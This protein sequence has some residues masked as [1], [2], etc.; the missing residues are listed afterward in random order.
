MP[1]RKILQQGMDKK[2]T[3]ILNTYTAYEKA[4]ARAKNDQKEIPNTFFP[5]VC[6]IIF[7]QISIP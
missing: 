1:F 7:Y 6:L 5:S 3:D 2:I 4:F